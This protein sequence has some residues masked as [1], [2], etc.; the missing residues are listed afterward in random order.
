[1]ILRHIEESQLGWGLLALGIPHILAA[2]CLQRSA[3]AGDPELARLME[4]GARRLF[5]TSLL[6]PSIGLALLLVLIVGGPN[7]SDLCRVYLVTTAVW[8]VGIAIIYLRR[9]EQW[10][11]WTERMFAG[12][13]SSLWRS[14][15]RS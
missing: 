8:F 11:P 13:G 15:F 14:L 3:A 6:L 5:A 10:T 4:P 12:V 1:L 2:N 7:S 9:G